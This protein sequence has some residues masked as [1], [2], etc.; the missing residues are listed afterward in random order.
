LFEAIRAFTT[1]PASDDKEYLLCYLIFGVAL[2]FEGL[3]G[4]RA[5]RQTRAEARQLNRTVPRH[6]RLSPDPT[7]KTVVSEDAVAVVGNVLGIAAT[8]ARQITGQSLWDGVAALGIMA[9]LILVALAL[10]QDN[11]GLLI[12][13]AIEPEEE[14]KIVDLHRSET[15]VDDVL[16]IVTMR[17]GPESTLVAARISF[18]DEV[19]AADIKKVAADAEVGVRRMFPEV[20]RVIL[21]LNTA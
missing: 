10:A 11:R 7:V 16:D 8:A 21:A 13:E 5:Y 3:S 2:V 1:A 19:K 12:G 9:M 17:L 18:S 20:A 6:I 15:A 4:L 14:R